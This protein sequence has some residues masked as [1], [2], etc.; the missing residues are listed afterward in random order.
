[1]SFRFALLVLLTGSGLAQDT[2]RK[3]DDARF[4]NVEPVYVAAYQLQPPSNMIITLV[5]YPQI[6]RAALGYLFGQL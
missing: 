2:G 6:I 5:D 3:G 1:M 4:Q